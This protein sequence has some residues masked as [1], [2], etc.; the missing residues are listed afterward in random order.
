MW[1]FT[2]SLCTATMAAE[3]DVSVPGLGDVRG[4]DIIPGQSAP[5]YDVVG[6]YGI[7]FAKAPVGELRWQP[8]QPYGAWDGLLDGTK[9]GKGCMQAG[10]VG[11]APQAGI[12]EDCLFLEVATPPNGLVANAK[13]PVMFWIHGGAY[14]SGSADIYPIEGLVSSSNHSV[15]VVATNYRLGPFGFLGGSEIQSATSDGSSGNFGIQDQRIAMV[16]TRDHIGAFGGNGADVTIFG[17]S[18]GGN[19]VINHLSAPASFSLYKRAIVE[20]G[21]YTYGASDMD[22][23][24]SDFAK[25]KKSLNC[26]D[27]K[28]LLSVNAEDLQSKASMQLTGPVVDGVELVAAPWELVRQGKHNKDVT[29][30]VGSVRDEG[31]LITASLPKKMNVLEFDVAAAASLAAMAPKA[32]L[33]EVKKIYN[34]SVYPYPADLG[35]ASKWWWEITRIGTDTVPGLG[36]CGTRSYARDLLAG[37]SKKVFTYL[38]AKPS[39]GAPIDPSETVVAHAAEIGFVFG[40]VQNMSIWPDQAELALAMAGY[41]SSFAVNDD[42]NH[43]GLPQWPAFT[44]QNDIAMRF[45]DAPSLG[46]V[47]IQQGL[48]KEACDYWDSVESSSALASKFFTDA[49]VGHPAVGVVV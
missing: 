20:S 46:G 7:P 49:M 43:E 2:A 42:P 11:G 29:V 6:F 10:G 23:A 33:A 26:A 32:K 9:Y 31:A 21:T 5:Y 13:L 35:G 8:P 27:L 17:E 4:T 45:D 47:K 16:W 41:W 40:A 12:S 38:F 24:D 3:Y 36:A 14:V 15:V 39:L 19:S 37:G 44:A 48:R 22:S 1:R 34:P 30:M 18:A 25:A 28:C